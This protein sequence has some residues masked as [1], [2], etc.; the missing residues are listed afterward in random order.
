MDSISE[1]LTAKFDGALIGYLRGIDIACVSRLSTQRLKQNALPAIGLIESV[2]GPIFE[3]HYTPLYLANFHGAEREH[4]DL[5]INRL[6]ERHSQRRRHDF[7]YWVI[8]V[9]D[10]S[11]QAAAAAQ[12]SVFLQGRHAIPYL[13]YIYVRP[14]SRRKDLS[15]VLHTITLAVAMAEAAIHHPDAPPQVPFT[16]CETKPA[17]HGSN[18]ETKAAAAERV[19]IHAKSG[20]QALMVRRK[21]HCRILTAHCQPGL[22][23][24]QPPLTLIWVLRPNPASPLTIA[25]ENLGKSIIASYYQNLRNEGFPEENIALA[26]SLVEGRLELDHEFCLIP[27]DEVAKEMYVDID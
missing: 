12:F 13:Q 22:E 27:L 5:I 15:E 21:G 11:G 19:S 1:L 4:P 24:G 23:N 17:V 18:A 14:Q 6:N 10:P 25:D 7:P 3:S 2:T 16:L 8:G 20:S 9:R 26:E